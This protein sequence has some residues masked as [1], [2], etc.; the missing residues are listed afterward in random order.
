MRLMTKIL[1]NQCPICG[2]PLSLIEVER[3]RFSLTLTGKKQ[4]YDGEEFYDAYL[5]CDVCHSSF[6]ADKK[7]DHFYIKKEL[8]EVKFEIKAYNPFDISS[9][10]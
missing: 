2:G 7:G 8:P 6:D 9:Y 10:K 1:P 5:E 4:R 3:S